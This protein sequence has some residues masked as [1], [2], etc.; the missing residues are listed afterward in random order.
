M[1]REYDVHVRGRDVLRQLSAEPVIVNGK[2][3][4]P[5]LRPA[6]PGSDAKLRLLNRSEQ[7]AIVAAVKAK[8]RR[9]ARVV[10]FG[11]TV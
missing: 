8:R 2:P 5:M 1:P 6:L 10:S 9:T 3:H 4:Y 11:R 7:Q